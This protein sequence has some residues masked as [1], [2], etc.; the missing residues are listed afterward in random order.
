GEGA[1]LEQVTAALQILVEGTAFAPDRSHVGVG[2]RLEL[3]LVVVGQAQVFRGV[4]SLTTDGR[5]G[6]SGIDNGPRLVA[7]ARRL[8]RGLRFDPEHRRPAGNDADLSASGE[9]RHGLDQR[10]V[11]RT[12]ASAFSTTGR[13]FLPSASTAS[14][15]TSASVK[16]LWVQAANS[17]MTPSGSQ[18]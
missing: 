4:L 11:T 6:T 10:P 14:W 12:F 7:G 3:L 8:H 13:D 15:A 17:S 1:D 18:K 16:P 9:R 5:S 2:Q